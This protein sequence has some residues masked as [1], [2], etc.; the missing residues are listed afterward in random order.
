MTRMIPCNT[1]KGRLI[2]YLY[3]IFTDVDECEFIE[4]LHI[5]CGS[6]AD[7]VNTP[8]SYDCTCLDGYALDVNGFC[9]GEW[10]KN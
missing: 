5:L 3:V 6:N 1:F 4:L 7:C 8:G 9:M 2:F 10:K